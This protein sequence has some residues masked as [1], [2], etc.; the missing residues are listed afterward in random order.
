[1][2]WLHVILKFKASLSKVSGKGFVMA[3]L[4]AL[5]L[6][7]AFSL[8]PLVALL[9]AGCEGTCWFQGKSC[10]FWWLTSCNWMCV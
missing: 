4:N 2:V 7:C 8:S 9:H 5:L 10:R 1:M 3:L 6:S